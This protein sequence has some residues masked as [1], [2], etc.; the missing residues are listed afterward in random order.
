MPLKRKKNQMK[1]SE[2]SRSLSM[3]SASVVSVAGGLDGLLDV[4]GLRAASIDG[5]VTIIS[6][7]VTAATALDIAV[8]MPEGDGYMYVVTSSVACSEPAY[9]S[10]TRGATV[11][12]GTA[13]TVASSRYD[14]T[15]VAAAVASPTVEDAGTTILTAYIGDRRGGGMSDEAPRV[16]QAGTTAMLRVTIPQNTA[17]I[18]ATITVQR[19]PSVA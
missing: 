6:H 1:N 15:P 4:G 9:V 2:H 18:G 17:T 14:G 10:I 3:R 12:G 19:I 11:T 5:A 16:Y 8:T 13:V 7:R